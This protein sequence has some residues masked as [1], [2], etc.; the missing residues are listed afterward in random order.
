MREK[1]FGVPP[2][3]ARKTVRCTAFRQEKAV[4]CTA[5]RRQKAVRCTAFRRQKAARCTAFRREKIVRCTAFRRNFSISPP[6]GGTPYGLAPS[7]FGIC[8]LEFHP[9]RLK[10]GHHTVLCLQNLG[11]VIWNFTYGWD[12]VPKENRAPHFRSA[13]HGDSRLSRFHAGASAREEKRPYR[14]RSRMPA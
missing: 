13:S 10:A 5:F 4:R 3:G 14:K 2:S 8:D 12:T 1:P 9:G 6:K 11:F 7:E